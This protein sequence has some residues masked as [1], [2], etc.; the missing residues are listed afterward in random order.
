MSHERSM[1]LFLKDFLAGKNQ[2]SGSHFV[3]NRDPVLERVEIPCVWFLCWIFLGGG[4][5]AF[6]RWSGG[7]NSPL[8]LAGYYYCWL[9]GIQCW[10]S[11]GSIGRNARARGEGSI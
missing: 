3:G 11:A 5:L 7:V 2:I 9:L 4:D 1:C 6:R 10:V 8:L